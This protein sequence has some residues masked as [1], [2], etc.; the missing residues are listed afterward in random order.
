MSE[1]SVAT[2]IPV[3]TI[4]YYLREGLLAPGRPLG[5]NLADYDEGH[6]HRLALVR[7]LADYG[8]L[9]I[10]TIRDLIGHVEGAKSSRYGLLALAQTAMTKWPAPRG[11]SHLAAAERLMDEMMARRGWTRSRAAHRAVRMAVGVLAVLGELGRQD[12]IAAL[13]AY[14]AAADRIAA[15]DLGVL[16]GAV[17]PDASGPKDRE[18]A[19]E[20][21]VVAASLGDALISALRRIA[22]VEQPQPL[23]DGQWALDPGRAV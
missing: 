14:A 23:Q 12:M 8:G 22:Q 18:R 10:V 16:E 4:K 21:V 19:V 15:I 9:P 17:R 20:L 6:V 7:A 3:A 2:G 1:L 5:R 13:D 11:G